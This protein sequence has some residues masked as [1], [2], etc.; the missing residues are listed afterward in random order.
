[1]LFSRKLF[2]SAEI[3]SLIRTVTV[4]L[5]KVSPVKRKKKRENAL[6]QLS[7]LLNLTEK[8]HK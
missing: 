6:F 1:M 8:S 7:F 3:N 4:W 5:V 2:D